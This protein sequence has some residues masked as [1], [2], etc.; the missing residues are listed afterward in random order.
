MSIMCLCVSALSVRLFV[1]WAAAREA[2][3]F[4][5]PLTF[6]RFFED[7]GN[8]LKASADFAKLY[9]PLMFGDDD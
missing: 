2:G 6:G 3:R 7:Y 9:A 4:A 5:A 1:L 8:C